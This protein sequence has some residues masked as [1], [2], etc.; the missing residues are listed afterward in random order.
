MMIDV[1]VGGRTP[2]APGQRSKEGMRWTCPLSRASAD[3]VQQCQHG[4][5][6]VLE[7]RSCVRMQ[8]WRGRR[9]FGER[10][11]VQDQM[12]E[13]KHLKYTFALQRDREF[14]DS[15]LRREPKVLQHPC[16]AHSAPARGR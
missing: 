2:F 15:H 3:P 13:G 1:L 4:R 12:L 8:F 16:D 10:K 6:F 14:S 5:A 7:R 9:A 11:H